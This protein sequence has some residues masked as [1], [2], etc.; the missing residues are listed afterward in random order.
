M[1]CE[2]LPGYPR[3]AIAEI[4]DPPGWRLVITGTDGTALATA[5]VHR[6]SAGTAVV[7]RL[8]VHPDHCGQGIGGHLLNQLHPPRHGC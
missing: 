5:V 1:A 8:A 6:S 2:R 3:A 7:G 4:A